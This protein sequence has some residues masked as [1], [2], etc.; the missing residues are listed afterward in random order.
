MSRP[1]QDPLTGQPAEFLF[2]ANDNRGIPGTFDY[3]RGP[4]GHVFIGEIPENLGDHYAG[5]YQPIPQTEAELAEAAKG[6]AYRLD[7]IRELVP[8][9]SFLEIG[10]WIGLVSYSALKAGYDVS[11]LERDPRC[12]S[13]LNSVGITATRTDDPASMLGASGER[14]DV[15]GLWHSIEHIPHPWK[16]IDVAARALKPGGILVV[17]APNPESAQM[18]VLGK[19]WVHLDA[20]RHIHFLPMKVIE[21]IGAKH[22][23]EVVERTTD[24]PLGKILDRAGWRFQI[25]RKFLLRRFH[26]RIP[27]WKWLAWRHRKTSLDG[28]GYTLI[29]RKSGG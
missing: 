29:L 19:H 25:D 13:L 15:I 20:P 1:M 23:L 21:D 18:K 10:P 8:S 26:H 12:V 17:A 22:G 9:G 4:T 2:T 7:R 3:Y 28:A 14:Y 27:F 5:G 6:D 11:V 24:D 16:M